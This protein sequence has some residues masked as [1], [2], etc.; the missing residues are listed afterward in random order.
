MKVMARRS[1]SVRDIFLLLL[2]ALLWCAPDLYATQLQDIETPELVKRAQ[3]IVVGRCEKTESRWNAGHRL[4]STYATYTVDQ[5]VKGLSK[6]KKDHIVLKTL[7]GTVGTIGQM[8]VGGPTFKPGDHDILFLVTSDEPDVYTLVGA[9]GQGKMK[10]HIDPKT[11]E[12]KVRGYTR[13][14]KKKSPD[15]VPGQSGLRNAKKD[16]QHPSQA[17]SNDEPLKDVLEDLEQHL[18]SVHS[19][20]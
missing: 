11:K 9:M 1:L 16:E 14:S 12:Q 17:F 2:P 19:Q 7:G 20:R 4:I 8:V 6:P 15:Q 10:V 5:A 18:A 13:M 3:A